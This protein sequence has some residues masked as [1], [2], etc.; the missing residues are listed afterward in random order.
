MQ[1]IDKVRNGCIAFVLFMMG[2]MWM[3][4]AVF[5]NRVAL[6]LA[7]YAT[8]VGVV[9]LVAI[10]FFSHLVRRRNMS[11]EEAVNRDVKNVLVFGGLAMVKYDD[12]RNIV[13]ISDMLEAM[14]LKITGLKLLDWQPTLA[15]LFD[16]DDIQVI[17]IKGKRFE[18]YNAEE[19]KLI[20]LKDVTQYMSLQQDFE[21]QQICMAYI[22]IDNYE[23]SIENADE[24]TAAQ[25]Q[26]VCRQV[27]VD[28][29]YADGM[30][31][32]SYRTGGYVAFFNERIYRKQ[33]ENK[34]AILD[35]FKKKSADIDAMMTLSIGIGRGTSVLKELEEL[36]SSALQLTYSRGGDQVAIKSGKD[37]V[38]YFGGKSDAY[39]K[40][41]KV[42]TR[43]IANSLAGLIKRSSN[44]YVMGHRMS[45]LDSLGSSIGIA[46]IVQAYD[47]RVAIVIDDNSLEEKTRAV[48]QT[49]KN[50]NRYDGMLTGPNEAVERVN[51][52]TL[53][54]VVDNHK[55]SLAISSVLLDMVKNK[56]IIDHHRRGE[57][58]ISTPVL[59]YLE[60]SASSA[61]ELITELIDYQ[62]VDVRINERDA[63][64]MYAGMLVDT[65]F[66]QQRVGVRTFQT[67]AKLKD[68]NASVTD[69]YEL[70]QDSFERTQEIGELER[71]AELYTHHIVIA[72]GRDDETH[73]QVVL[74]KTSNNLLEVSDVMAAFTIG[75]T[76]KNKVN[77]SARSSHTI[78]VQMIMESLGGG[79]HFSMAACALEGVTTEQACQ[80]LKEAID[81][82]FE[83]RSQEE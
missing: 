12:S 15:S 36:A 48:V 42:R 46:R 53:L 80:R 74:A 64:I 13:W 83:E 28:W 52:D 37:K 11:V 14:N 17:D 41:S 51:K 34:F 47:K 77:I 65:H 50:D 55:P 5:N 69:A 22:S 3:G 49:M 29:A 23:E 18:A 19:S 63:T 58:F 40:S 45:D 66:F 33:L 30:I 56:V 8:V 67:A 54:I 31:L 16:S 70:L 78:N 10:T 60:P 27:I 2:L 72:T 62:N 82:Y 44:V 24:A 43:V 1:T 6:A 76:A 4:E 81:R 7:L 9:A 75:R 61:V 59:T 79:G 39:E 26:S 35:T 32:R 25:I 57:E 68:F 21:D 38:R 73:E 71:T 20:Y